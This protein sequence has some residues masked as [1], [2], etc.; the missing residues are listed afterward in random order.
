MKQTV[1]SRHISIAI[2]P[3]GPESLSIRLTGRLDAS[4]AGDIWQE[5]VDCARS[6][7]WKTITVD[8]AG[9]DYVDGT[10]I[11]LL[12]QLKALQAAR[13]DDIEIQGL[14]PKFQQLL[15]MFDASDL[16]P[17][18]LKKAVKKRFFDN[19]GQGAARVFADMESLVSY[20]GECFASLGSA[21]AHPGRVRWKDVFLLAEKAG[22]DALPIICLIGFLMGLIMSFQSA[23]T[24]V[25]F[26][27]EIFVA[28]LLGLSM[29]R[30]L[31]PLM[32]TILLASRSGSAFAAEIGTMKV[33]DEVNA[34]NEMGLK[35]V[36]FLAVPRVL[37]AVAMTPLLTLFFIFFSL[38]GGAVVMLSMGYPLS[39]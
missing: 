37:A 2:N 33:N 31:G 32:T 22:I 15:D 5:T 26:G 11:G 6:G 19:V 30:E 13:G 1:N 38:F 27:A 9:L 25:R 20:V 18:P 3:A 10:G 34:L 21:L 28:D 35:P 39:T 17:P 36:G 23:I 29:F 7:K 14:K 8:S 24:L 12:V 16:V 4:S